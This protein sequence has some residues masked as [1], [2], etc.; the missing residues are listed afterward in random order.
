MPTELLPPPDDPGEF[1]SLC[2]ELW[3]ELWGD[4]EAQKNGRRGQ[5]QAGVDVFGKED[6][7]WVGVQSKQKSGLLHTQVS[8]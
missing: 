8:V 1:E 7:Q 6:G 4:S 3:G 2:L 5:A